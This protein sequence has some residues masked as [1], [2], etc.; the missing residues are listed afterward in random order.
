MLRWFLCICS[1]PGTEESRNR[2]PETGDPDQDESRFPGQMTAA[3]HSKDAAGPEKIYRHSY[4]LVCVTQSLVSGISFCFW[5]MQENLFGLGFGFFFPLFFFFYF[6]FSFLFLYV[7]NLRVW[8]IPSEKNSMNSSSNL[9]PP[10]PSA[11]AKWAD[12][13]HGLRPCKWGSSTTQAPPLPR[14]PRNCFRIGLAA[15]KKKVSFVGPQ[16]L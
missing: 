8:R 13:R 9:A 10:L 5:W 12:P 14:P 2:R 16:N 15:Y 3:F 4:S 1:W 7:E 6:F 11:W